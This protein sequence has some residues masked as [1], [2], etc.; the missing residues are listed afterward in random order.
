MAKTE[1]LTDPVAEALRDVREAE[2]RGIE[3]LRSLRERNAATRAARRAELERLQA[4][5]DAEQAEAERVF[6]EAEAEDRRRRNLADAEAAYHTELEKYAPLR[7]KA[8]QLIQTITTTLSQ[9]VVTAGDAILAERERD[10]AAKPLR[11]AF[12]RLAALAPN[13]PD[14]GI[15]PLR[16]HDATRRET[17]LEMLVLAVALEDPRFAEQ[18]QQIIQLLNPPKLGPRINLVVPS[19]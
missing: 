8:D 11:Q 14:P 13:T 6:R 19:K 12:D 18:K 7:D 3:E 17:A 9:L 16:L 4:V 1:D 2:Q 10:Q 5:D 15:K